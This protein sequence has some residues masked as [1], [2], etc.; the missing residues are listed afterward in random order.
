M[1]EG[2]SNYKNLPIELIEKLEQITSNYSKEVLTA[3]INQKAFTAE[4]A[5]AILTAKGV[6]AAEIEEIITL[7]GLTT[8]QKSSTVAINLNTMSKIGN[9]EAT[10]AE[11]SEEIKK[12]LYKYHC[13]E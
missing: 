8:A 2:I 1:F 7:A 5:R 10:E 6:E 9:K 4:Q 12:V 13:L 11:I 3:T